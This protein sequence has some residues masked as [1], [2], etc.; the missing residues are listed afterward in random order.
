MKKSFV[1][2]GGILF[3][4]SCKPMYKTSEFK[5]ATAP[6]KPDYSQTDQWAVLP[7]QLPTAL[8]EII[9]PQ[10][11]KP[12]DVFFIYPTL[13][14]DKKNPAW[15]ADYRQQNIRANV[16]EKSAAFQ[17]SAWCKAANLYMPFYR[18]AHYRIFVDS[19]ASQGIE[20]GKL[21]YEDIKSAFEYYLTHHNQGKPIIIAAHSQGS[22]HAKRLVQDFFDGKP[23]QN[24]LIAAYLIGVKIEPSMFKNIPALNTPESI[25]GFVSWNTY[26]NNKLPKKYNQWYKGGI[27]TNPL[28]WNNDMYSDNTAHLGVLNSDKKIYPQSLSIQVIDGMIWSSVPRIPKRFLLSFVKNYHFADINLFWGNI[29]EN[30]V[31]RT[32]AWLNKYKS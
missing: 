17:A 22:L 2:L 26:K 13:F 24:Q 10:E 4:L 23:L 1:V 15:N 7:N 3:F 14:T 20:A 31:V 11:T 30:A 16:L 29:E 25:G 32:Q 21:A 5:I 9:G 6:P 28:T 27:A 8:Q 19:F 18:Q 12:A